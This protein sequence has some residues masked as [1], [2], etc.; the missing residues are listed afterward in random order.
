MPLLVGPRLSSSCVLLSVCSCAYV[1][2]CVCVCHMCA[3]HAADV[4][5][6]EGT[7]TLNTLESLGSMDSTTCQPKRTL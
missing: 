1:G 6:V 2:V 3:T 4:W 7:S 5:R